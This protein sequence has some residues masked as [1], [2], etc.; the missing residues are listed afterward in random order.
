MRG[1]EKL[2]EFHT[3]AFL[4]GEKSAVFTGTAT[5]AAMQYLP[6]TPN[7][8]AGE[9]SAYLSEL[10]ETGRI[11]PEQAAVADAEAIGWFTREPLF[12]RMADAV[13]LEREMPFSY[14]M[15]AEQLFG[16]AAE[17]TVLLQ[18][19]LDACFLENDG[20][21]IVD[22]KTDRIRPNESAEQ[23]AARHSEQLRLYAL[24]LESITGKRVKEAF[25]VLLSYHVS[26]RVL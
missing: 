4:G 9:I 3:P 2:P 6:L 15:D 12:L 24:A 19:V 17:E 8:S 21:V 26:V 18:G 14:P 22:Y 7:Q 20:W 23:A 11:T 16:I 5:H 25:V 1:E 10:A 13:R